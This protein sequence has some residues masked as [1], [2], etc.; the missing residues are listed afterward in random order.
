MKKNKIK[1]IALDFEGT[2]VSSAVSLFARPGLFEFLEFCKTNFE[3]VEMFT[4]VDEVSFRKC[5]SLLFECGDVPEWFL[6]IEYTHWFE[7]PESENKRFKDLRC[8]PDANI[9]EILIVDDI[10]FFIREEQKSQYIHIEGFGAPY[11]DD[12]KELERITKLLQE[13]LIEN[14]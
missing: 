4:Y 1:V 8:I 6:N 10:E 7:K 3:R 13:R 12:D 5:V 11:S 14:T 9:D 2:L